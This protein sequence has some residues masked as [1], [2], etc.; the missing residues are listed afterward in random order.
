MNDSELIR[1]ILLNCNQILVPTRRYFAILNVSTAQITKWMDYPNVKCDGEHP[2]DLPS[3]KYSGYYNKTD[4]SLYLLS[5][6]GMIGPAILFKVNFKQKKWHKLWTGSMNKLEKFYSLFAK[7]AKL[8]I[9]I[10]KKECF[11]VASKFVVPEYN[12][13]THDYLWSL[14][15]Y[16][17]DID[18][19]GD[20][21]SHPWIQ[22]SFQHI[23]ELDATHSDCE[24]YFNAVVTTE[25]V[26]IKKN[27][28][29]FIKQTMNEAA[30]TEISLSEEEQIIDLLQN[31]PY[32]KKALIL[33]ADNRFVDAIHVRGNILL[34]FTHSK[35]NGDTLI[36]IVNFSPKL[37]PQTN[38]RSTSKSYK[39][40]MYWAFLLENIDREKLTVYGW[41]RKYNLLITMLI[42]DYLISIICKYYSLDTIIIICHADNAYYFSIISVDKILNQEPSENS[43][44]KK[45]Q[46]TMNF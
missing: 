2:I 37:T 23:A 3:V 35:F 29:I 17:C 24:L 18:D 6:H 42:P 41:I 38:T 46:A 19:N 16:K 30:I 21:T 8:S 11:I 39:I 13:W 1:P 44:I 43:E 31:Q 45:Y 22:K 5:Y 7:L 40:S 28:L 15:L 25:H 36:D 4:N 34:L 20:T 9:H 27:K 33:R 10:V 12:I 14:D 26:R 32:A